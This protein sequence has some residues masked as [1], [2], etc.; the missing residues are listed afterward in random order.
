LLYVCPYACNKCV[1]GLTD[2]YEIW[3]CELLVRLISL[4]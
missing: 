3:Y 4:V 2:C 1:L